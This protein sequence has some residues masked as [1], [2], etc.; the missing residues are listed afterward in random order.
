MFHR[1]AVDLEMPR[2]FVCEVYL[3]VDLVVATDYATHGH[4]HDRGFHHVRH[5]RMLDSQLESA[6][7]RGSSS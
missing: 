6:D 7:S 2:R 5:V 3:A 1:D 4:R